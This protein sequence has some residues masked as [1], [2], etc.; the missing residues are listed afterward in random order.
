M[1]SVT[2]KAVEQF[3]IETGL[4][5]HRV[6]ILLAGNGR[7]LER[8][9]CNRRFWPETEDKVLNNLAKQRKKRGLPSDG[10]TSD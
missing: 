6:G 7:L 8:I 9:R 4:S 5:E 1:K 2:K 3:V 10:A